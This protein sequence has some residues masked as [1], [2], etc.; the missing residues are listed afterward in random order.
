[1]LEVRYIANKFLTFKIGLSNNLWKKTRIVL[2]QQNYINRTINT[3]Y[4]TH[5]RVFLKWKIG[6]KT[7]LGRVKNYREESR[8]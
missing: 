7:K 4:D 3:K 2:Q 8:D 5:M 1:M 6:N